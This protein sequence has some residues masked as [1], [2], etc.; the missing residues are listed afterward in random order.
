ML[1]Y[2]MKT[3]QSTD[4]ENVEQLRSLLATFRTAYF[5][6]ERGEHRPPHGEPGK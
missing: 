5:G 2:A 3:K 1:V 4:L 6:A